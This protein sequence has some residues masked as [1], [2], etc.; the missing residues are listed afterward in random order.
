M[1]QTNSLS[2]RRSCISSTTQKPNLY[3]AN[4]R[5]QNLSAIHDGFRVHRPTSTFSVP[6]LFNI[7]NTFFQV[8]H[9]MEEEIMLPLR[10]KDM[11][12]EGKN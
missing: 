9:T 3:I 1:S 2:V 5:R 7:M 10:L 6:L 4:Q 8:T 11:P 12:V